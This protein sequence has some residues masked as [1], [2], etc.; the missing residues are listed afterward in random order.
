MFVGVSAP[1][2]IGEEF[3]GSS[4]FT[5]AAVALPA[6]PNGEPWRYAIA[7]TNIS[8]AQA[9][10]FGDGTIDAGVTPHA[11]INRSMPKFI[12][13]VSGRTH[14]SV[15][16]S[17]GGSWRVTPVD[18]IPQGGAAVLRSPPQIE[19]ADEWDTTA[20][21]TRALPT[22]ASGDPAKYVML[23]QTS[24]TALTLAFGDSTVTG[25]ATYLSRDMGPV[26]LNVAGQT[27]LRHSALASNTLLV[28]ALEF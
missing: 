25:A 13:N 12:L 3:A 11:Y 15:A 6:R 27:H 21:A 24:I 14:V 19:N 17:G 18:N 9:V 20:A 2:Q 1:P 28:A 8:A 5:G 26:V 23:Q 10:A 16:G 7:S 4:V 22:R